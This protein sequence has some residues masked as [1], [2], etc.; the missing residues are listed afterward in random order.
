[1]G[2]TRLSQVDP[3][4][5]GLVRIRPRKLFQENTSEVQRNSR[6]FVFRDSIPVAACLSSMPPTPVRDGERACLVATF[7]VWIAAINEPTSHDASG[8]SLRR[9]MVTT[10]FGRL[11]LCVTAPMRTFDTSS[12]SGRFE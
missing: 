4:G 3:F 5:D 2:V 7:G 10:R 6:E 8:E 12:G 1:M 9:S 11:F